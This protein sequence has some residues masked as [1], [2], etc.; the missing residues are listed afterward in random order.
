MCRAARGALAWGTGDLA[1][2]AG[3]GRTTVVRFEARSETT[4]ATIIAIRD[5]FTREGIIF[6]IDNNGME[7]VVFDGKRHRQ[8]DG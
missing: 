7:H 6:G 3:V 5:A 4:L 1:K 8:S 2:A